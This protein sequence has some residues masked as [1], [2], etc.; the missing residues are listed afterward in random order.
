MGKGVFQ[1]T[2][3]FILGDGQKNREDA[4]IAA[5]KDWLKTPEHE[6]FFLVPNYNKFEREVAL[7]QR[8]KDEEK[9]DFAS[10]RGQVYSFHRLSWYYLQQTGLVNEATL[11]ETGAAMIMRK[12]LVSL[13]EELVLYRG[14]LNKAGFIKQLLAFHQEMQISQVS[15]DDLRNPQTVATKATDESLKFKELAL[16]Y[17][18]YEEQ[19]L[20]RNLQPSQPVSLLADYLKEASRINDY[21]FQQKPLDLQK[22]LYIISGYSSFSSQEQELVQVLM[23]KGHVILD[24]LLD[25]PY[26][27]EMPQPIDLFFESGRTYHQLISYAKAHNVQV[28]KDIYGKRT[29][30]IGYNE[31]AELWRKTQNGEKYHP[32]DEAKNSVKKY[33]HLWKVGTPEEE[34]RQ[35]AA[36]IRQLVSES[37]K[38]RQPI[39]YRDIQVLTIEPTIYHQYIP[40]L[41][42]E[43]EIPFYID[44]NLSMTQHPLVEFI[45]SL[46]AIEKYYYRI[47]DIFR[48][49]RTELYLPERLQAGDI[50]TARKEFRRLVDLTENQVLA[51]NFQ[52]AAWTTKK[53][54]QLLSYDFDEEI[55][56]DTKELTEYTN[57]LRRDFRQ[58]IGGFLKKLKQAK[59]NLEAVQLFYQ[60]LI[61]GA[62]EAQLLYWRNQAVAAGELE[63]GRNHEQAWQALMELLDEFVLIYGEEE[64]SFSLFEEILQTGLENLTFGKIPT[65]L[66]QVHI[67]RFD[68]VRPKQSRISF[69][70][71]LNDTVLP[72][73]TEN[74]TLLTNEERE[75]LN[76]GFSGTAHLSEIVKESSSKEP[77]IFYN[78]LLSASDQL[79]LSYANNFDTQQNL[80]MSTYLQRLTTQLGV[81]AENRGI[82]NLDSPPEH[83][84]GTYRSLIYQLNNLQQQAKQAQCSLPAPWQSLKQELLH[85]EQAQLAL[86]VFASQTQKNVPVPLSK[87][88]AIA[89][90][91]ESIYSSISKIE[92]FYQCEY[93]Y[94]VSFGLR[95][96]E[97]DIYGLN[98]AVT[99][100]F[101]HDALDQFMKV[102]ITE[103]L[104]LTQLSEQQRIYFVDR[105]LQEIF[106]DVRYHLLSSSPRM[107]FIRYQLGKTIQRVAWALTKQGERMHFSPAKTEVLFGQIAGAKGVA[108]L[109]LPLSTGGKLHLRGK[110][111]RVDVAEINDEKWLTVVDYKSGK[112][113]F[114]VAEAYYGLAMQLVSYL[115]VALQD[116]ANL[117][118]TNTVKPAGAY[119]MHVHDPLLDAKD[120]SAESRLKKYKYDGFFLN[121]TAVF[122]AFDH[123]LDS[124]MNSAV[125]PLRKNKDDQYQAVSQSKNKFYTEE[126]IALLRQHNQKKMVDA[127]ERLL[128]GEIQLNPSYK[129][130]DKK[131][132]CQFC[133]FRS[134]CEFDV[135]LPENDYHRLESLSKEE[136]LNRIR[137]EKND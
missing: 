30:G 2:L 100:E 127:G 103:K 132:A 25:K 67:N 22:S 36:S 95:L 72:R 65:A 88:K 93:K 11:S 38:D 37:K 74:Q 28:F 14:E 96:K 58:D 70:P 97:R 32:S 94:F 42:A 117:V 73:K 98:A 79:Y 24:L 31:L 112:R 89:L 6:V 47:N 80:Q 55:L 49:L 119:Y 99:G 136:V 118:G 27:H 134:V 124:S 61:D 75:I 137:E 50:E 84:V 17:Q 107:N 46:F 19:L 48:L 4:F 126:E 92:T 69:V 106:G 43:Y 109:E 53:D 83:Y 108:G 63:Q 78:V 51:H 44:Q 90:Y 133:P 59:T 40:K 7:L 129:I 104:S 21:P 130:S 20:V 71:G 113:D 9:K 114:D 122:P 87:E 13:E 5:A 62:V 111:D 102:L 3:Q 35:I 39:R 135:M 81:T 105:V 16:I 45:Q 12:V 121:D 52:G 115:D 77:F 120:A 101:F 64:F 57:C 86:K 26:V 54:W 128:A 68:L 123:S 10:I 91:G 29:T 131:R 125:F 33:L 85:S 116:A 66:D 34:V 60:F 76:E 82:L 23:E 1:M 110:I 18:S 56:A 15:V 41:F 8:L